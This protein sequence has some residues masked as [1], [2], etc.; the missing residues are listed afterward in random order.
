LGQFEIFIG[1]AGKLEQIFFARVVRAKLHFFLLLAIMAT[2]GD[3]PKQIYSTAYRE[4]NFD[5]DV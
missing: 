2:Y 3:L 5:P 1:L 4:W